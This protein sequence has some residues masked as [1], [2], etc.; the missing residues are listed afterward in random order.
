MASR[1]CP[2]CGTVVPV[3][4]RFCSN[5]GTDLLAQQNPS[6]YG[7][8]SPQNYPQQRPPYGQQQF[9]QYQQPQQNQSPIAE[10]LGALGLLFLMRRY[11][12]GYQARRQS[13]GCCGCLIVL[14]ILTIF[15][16]IPGYF[17]V[18]TYYPQ[19]LQKLQNTESGNVPATQPLITTVNLN[20]KVNY[21]G[22]DITLLNAQQSTAFIDD[23]FTKTNGMVRLNIRE[24]NT[25]NRGGGYSYVDGFHLI[26]PDKSVVV[27]SNEKNGSA[28]NAGAT[29]DN[30][31][32][33]PVPTGTKMNQLALQLGT[34]QEA[35]MV[36]PLVTNA[37]L[38]AYQPLTV[39]PNASTVYDGVKWTINSATLSW[40]YNGKQATQG[41]RYVVLT[42]S[43]DN[44]SASDFNAYYGDYIRL[45]AGDTTSSPD[46]DSQIPLN[47][48]ANSTGTKATAFFLVPQ[49]VTAYTLI[50][51]GKPQNSPPISQATV[52]F[53]IR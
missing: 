27:V 35:Q 21:A 41:M 40:S 25:S 19:V 33:F 11:R 5:C 36:I 24:A 10:A 37:N 2:V 42:L 49:S 48:P 9:P 50:F 32:D 12:P 47:F 22:V 6:Q 38:K 15:V 52:N 8:S 4:Q 44:S 18:R 16:G 20:E 28:P 13:S 43:V 7:G 26:L 45:K 14:V 39:H 3:N 46:V 30:W 29:Q 1:S 34:T 17:A 23:D 51:L 31:L 53:T